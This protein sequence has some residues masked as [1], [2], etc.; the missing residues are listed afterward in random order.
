[1]YSPARVNSFEVEN[2]INRAKKGQSNRT[3]FMMASLSKYVRSRQ[4]E[5]HVTRHKVHFLLTMD[6]LEKNFRKI[7]IDHD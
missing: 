6:G 5:P 2:S 7:G 4:L 3:S 1:M